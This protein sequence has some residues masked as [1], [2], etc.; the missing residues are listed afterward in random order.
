MQNSTSGGAS[1]TDISELMVT[2]RQHD[3]LWST[4]TIV[5]PVGKCPM[6]LRKLEEQTGADSSFWPLCVI[7]VTLLW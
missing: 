2:P 7:K 4:V 5:T 3:S 6:I 1:E